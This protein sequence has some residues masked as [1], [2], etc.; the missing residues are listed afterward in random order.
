MRHRIDG[1]SF[2]NTF[3]PRAVMDSKNEVDVRFESG[4]GSITLYGN[5]TQI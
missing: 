5:G 3:L 1:T 2:S 4:I